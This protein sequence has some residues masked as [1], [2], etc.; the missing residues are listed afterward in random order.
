MRNHRRWGRK[1]GAVSGCLVVEEVTLK[2]K[3][4]CQDLGGKHSRQLAPHVQRPCGGSKLGV[5][6]DW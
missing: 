4:E 6:E 2:E 1:E 5:F 3:L